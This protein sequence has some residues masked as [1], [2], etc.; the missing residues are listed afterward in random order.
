MPVD[1]PA[2]PD[3]G[4]PCINNTTL[5][6]VA[7]CVNGLRVLAWISSTEIINTQTAVAT[8]CGDCEQTKR[9]L[10]ALAREQKWKAS[11]LTKA[12]EALRA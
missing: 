11:E 12:L 4:E 7:Q 5:V 6:L 9:D 1:L 2:F 10:I 3:E 8:G